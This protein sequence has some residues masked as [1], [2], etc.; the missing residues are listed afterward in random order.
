M[1]AHSR[2]RRYNGACHIRVHVPSIVVCRSRA[3]EAKRGR[4][5]SGADLA[6]PN[7]PTPMPALGEKGGLAS[8]GLS[9][10]FFIVFGFI[11]L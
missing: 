3:V 5:R 8:G 9:L 10:F 6:G 1:V 7:P 11:S 2:S 4:V